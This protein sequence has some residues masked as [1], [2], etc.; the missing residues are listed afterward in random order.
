MGKVKKQRKRLHEQIAQEQEAQPSRRTGKERN[1]AEDDAFVDEKLSK[2]ILAQAR[3]QEEDLDV[4]NSEDA[5]P[6]LSKKK[7][8]GKKAVRL[9]G[10]SAAAESDSEDEDVTKHLFENFSSLEKTVT[11]INEEDEEDLR[12]FMNPNPKERRTLADIICEK[13]AEKKT[14]MTEM[15]SE[16]PIIDEELDD[17]VR[18]HFIQIGDV[19]SHYRSG[20]L[21]KGFKVIPSF[22][23]WQQLVELTR[24]ENWTAASVYAATRIFVSNLPKYHFKEFCNLILLPRIR[25]DIAEYKRLN[26]HLFQAL[27]KAIYKPGDFYEG[28]VLPLCESGDCTLREALIVAGVVSQTSIPVGYSAAALILISKMEYNGANSIFMKTILNKKYSLPLSAIDAV[29]EHF[30]GFREVE[31]QMPVL[32]HQCLLTLVQRYKQDLTKEHKLGILRLIAFH[33]HH[34]ISPEIQREITSSKRNRGDPEPEDEDM[35]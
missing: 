34:E 35:M 23:H 4:S 19:L 31:D 26:F 1:R 15:M 9:G 13:L 3:K 5:W 16:A 27:H 8:S 17:N 25:D 32:W 29:V 21:P 33:D 30:M 24:P 28:I 18:Q 14:A 10:A 22:P 11:E 2:K 12:R 6:S 7:D 20:K